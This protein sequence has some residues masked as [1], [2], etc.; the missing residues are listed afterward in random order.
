[1]NLD[2]LA[3]DQL[4][5]EGLN[6]EAVQ[7]RCA[8][9]HHGVLGDD[10]FEHVPHHRTRTLD[11]ALRTLD[12]LR[13][14]EVDQP[15]HDER[16]EQ[17]ECHLL[18][19]TALV[20]L[21]LRADD[22][23]RTAGVV[24]TLAEQVL[25]EPAL[26]AL[27]Q[28]RQRLQRAVARAG[29]RPAAAAVV[30][31][32]VHRLLE[33]PLLVV[34]DDLRGAQVEQPL[35]P[36]VPVDDA[37]VQVVHV[38]GREAAAVELHHRAQVRRDDRDAVQHH[39]HGRVA[40]LL[41][42]RDDLEP[43]EGPQLALALAGADRL[44]QRGG[45]GVEVELGEQLLQRRGTHAALEVLTE[46]VAQ[47]AVERLV[48]D[49]LLDLELAEGVEHLLEAVDLP[50]RAVAHLAHLALAALAH[51]AAHVGLG[52]LG[53]QLGQVG[54]Q[55]LLAAL[56][57]GVAAGLE[58]VLL[59]ADLGLDGRQVAVAALV[60]DRGDQVGSEVD[61]LLEVLGRQVEQVAQ[62]RGDALE[63]PDVGDRSGQLDVAHPLTTH[64]GAS[65]LDAAALADDALEA[66]ALVLAA[67]ALPVPGGTEDLLAEEAVLLGTE[68]AVVDGLGL[69]HLTVR[70]LADVLAGGQPDAELVEE[71]DVEQSDDPF[72]GL[73]LLSDQ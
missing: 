4:R 31:Q 56:D 12:V 52:A 62:A 5:L 67:V 19:Q 73:V 37:A 64:L 51:L 21:Q 15:L 44:A 10:L 30:E 27:E 61:D 43:L 20:Q 17:L 55:L 70:P 2:G 45:L 18:G 66:D 42:R 65:H 54:L 50:L 24:D 38:A 29:D 1:M 36:V 28:V 11:H 22:D 33:H 16:L 53:L 23:D 63:E 8:V 69:L 72:Q 41:E 68:S 60:V 26:L 6:A 57:V 7:G 48:G 40:G 46:A 71:V 32:R 13:V 3:F 49:Q 34:D 9:E 59:R 14:V 35:E 47:L 39:A 25:P 58:V